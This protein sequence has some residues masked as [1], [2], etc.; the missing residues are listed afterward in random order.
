VSAIVDTIRWSK[1]RHLVVWLLS[2]CLVAGF[3]A[4]GNDDAADELAHQRELREQR[5]QGAQDER[6]RQL[7]RQ[8]REE[9]RKTHKRNGNAKED[10]APPATTA[11]TP[12]T[13]DPP[14]TTSCGGGLSVGPNTTC[15]FAQSVR[16]AYLGSGG[17]NVTVEAY[18]PVTQQLYTM[19]CRAGAPTTCTGGNNASV[20]IQ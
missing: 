19:S 1:A 9:R 2:G 15:A 10:P 4:C 18:S 20:F 12:A 17:G 7:E 8:L 6:L 14:A 3:A 13:P 11:P 16:E 5:R